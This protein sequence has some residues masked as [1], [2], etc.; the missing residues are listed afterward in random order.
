M[1]P[2]CIHIEA[3]F[4]SWRKWFPS[5][6]YKMGLGMSR[7]KA[8][9]ARDAADTETIEGSPSVRNDADVSARTPSTASERWPTFVVVVAIVAVMQI[10]SM[11][12]PPYIMPSPLTILGAIHE[13][14]V[15]DYR[16][17]VV[18]LLRL[19][20]ALVISLV[21]GTTLGVVMAMIPRIRP[22]LR[23][24]VI[25]DTGV[26]AVSW[27]LVAVFWFRDPEHRIMFIMLV[28]IVPFYALNVLDG[29]RAMPK[30]WLEMCQSFRP[31]RWQV[32]RYL[33]F[34][35]VVPYVL[36]T[37]KSVFGYATRMIIFAELIGAAVGAG[38]KMG[39]AQATFRMDVVLAWT[40]LLVTVNLLAQ[41]GVG[42]VERR[43]LK[44]RPDVEVR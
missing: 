41:A 31:R 7:G 25:I 4:V 13:L 36:M 21:I 18:T 8:E 34:P 3:R 39:L 9:M 32:F 5:L 24:L 19:S 14:L 1:R 6:V 11:F 38:A 27:I 20:I 22:Y 37:T 12:A 40:V 26:P 17:V 42:M 35:H 10:A 43:V 23:A 2:F 44:W 33:I 15:N 29:I 16:D 30:D 28:I